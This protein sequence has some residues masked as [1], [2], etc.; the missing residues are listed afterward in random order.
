MP[1]AYGLR[2]TPRTPLAQKE[3]H[4]LL[5][6][7][8]GHIPGAPS[9]VSGLGDG[10]GIRNHSFPPKCAASNQKNGLT[11]P[12]PSCNIMGRIQPPVERCGKLDD[13]QLVLPDMWRIMVRGDSWL[14]GMAHLTSKLQSLRKSK[15]WLHTCLQLVLGGRAETEGSLG[16]AGYQHSPL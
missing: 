9:C 6:L 12:E 1:F 2:E 14:K 8:P 4:S 7:L 5:L 3:Y 10:L 11:D 15:V 16:L 13:R